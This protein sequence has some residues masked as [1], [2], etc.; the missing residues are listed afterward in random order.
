MA[1]WLESGSQPVPDAVCRMAPARTVRKLSTNLL[2]ETADHPPATDAHDSLYAGS[3]TTNPARSAPDSRSACQAAARHLRSSTA[4]PPSGFQQVH[5]KC[6]QQKDEPDDHAEGEHDI[7][8]GHAQH[9][10]PEGVDHVQNR[11]GL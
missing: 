4:N 7:D 2:H 10:I 5:G 9:A 8:V 3:E 11:V 6:A 1:S